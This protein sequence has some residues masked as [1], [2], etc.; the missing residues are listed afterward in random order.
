[1]QLVDDLRR[2]ERRS[3][4]DAFHRAVFQALLELW[5]ARAP[6]SR[7]EYAALLPS[8]ARWLREAPLAHWQD[9][10][11][12]ITARK[13]ILACVHAS[14][15]SV[16]AFLE[17]AL[18]PL[19]PLEDAKPWQRIKLALMA[20]VDS[21]WRPDLARWSQLSPAQAM[22]YA[23]AGLWDEPLGES[24]LE[25]FNELVLAI[26][27]LATAPLPFAC[28]GDLAYASYI[29]GFA[30]ARKKYDAKRV[31][32]EQA[33]VMLA[34]QKIPSSAIHP[35]ERQRP[36]LALIAEKY[37]A[38]NMMD[39]CYRELLGA[40]KRDFEVELFAETPS[41]SDAHLEIAHRA[42]YFD[43]HPD[44]VGELIALV[45]RSAP[46]VVYYPSV[47]MAPWT[48]AASQLRLA[49]LQVAGLGHPCPTA[50]PAIDFLAVQPELHDAEGSWYEPP[51]YYERHPI[52]S[53]HYETPEVSSLSEKRL[54]R[55]AQEPMRIAVNASSM[56]LNAAFLST[57]RRIA[58]AADRPV[59]LRFFP[60]GE[61][62][63][64][65]SLSRRIAEWFPTAQTL[66]GMPFLPY[67]EALA[68]CDLALQSFPF[69]GTNTT[70]DALAI[71]V[72][73]VCLDGP[74]VHS[75]IDAMILRRAKLADDLLAPTPGR[76]ES[77]AL[78]LIAD[79]KERERIAGVTRTNALSAL[80]EERGGESFAKAV[81]EA[82]RAR[83]DGWKK[84]S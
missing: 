29:V 61:G 9:G 47:G 74:E 15:E 66:P 70:L 78:R 65:A 17:S 51:L 46:D 19:P 11:R 4:K 81:A 52:A 62:V 45:R 26:P 60:H 27:A 37:Y 72:P 31:L 57:V 12:I 75:R 18:G 1:V 25:R 23:I 79:A 38:G 50:S 63:R 10:F 73:V 7:A 42:T 21:G 84:S 39:R 14:G 80:R 6:L 32:G 40:L 68:E 59:E 67:L 43:P 83:R 33:R 22:T 49:P 35:G 8:L 41:R 69:G 77:I 34:K 2:L 48:F 24:A 28:F 53:S 3:S 55:S 64:H 16:D 44:R 56:K 58:H 5:K 20:S 13:C 30:T 76:Y 82:W 54:T 71:G 36:R